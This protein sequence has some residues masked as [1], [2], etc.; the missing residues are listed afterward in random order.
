MKQFILYIFALC[1]AV[2][3]SG[4]VYSVK[5]VPNVQLADGR[6][7][8]SNPDGILSAEAVRQID[9]NLYRLKAERKAQIAVV[10]VQSIGYADPKQ[11]ATE[12]FN[13]WHIGERRA[14][15]GLLILLATNERAVE[16]ETG[17]GLEGTLGDIRLS[18]ILEQY[19]FPA[20]REG[21]WDGGMLAG[22]NTITSILDGEQ[23]AGIS[24]ENGGED[25]FVG[26]MFAIFGFM[27]IIVIALFASRKRCPRCHKGKVVQQSSKLVSDTKLTKT[28]EITYH[29]NHCRHTWTE[30]KMSIK[31]VVSA[32]SVVE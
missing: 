18:Q 22:V 12:L 10:V 28:Y 21:D 6:R 9:A 13:T 1:C 11:F 5:D 23:P 3:V 20:F 15:N 31:I 14:D 17:Y 26:V 27:S 30:K 25:L 7:F 16:I 2:S 8:V 32:A 24:G 19:M 4:Q 29:C